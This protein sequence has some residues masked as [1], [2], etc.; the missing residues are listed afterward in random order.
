MKV[1]LTAFSRQKGGVAFS[2]G[3]RDETGTHQ[4]IDHVR[5][6]HTTSSFFD[7]GFVLV[8]SESLALPP[9]VSFFAALL[10]SNRPLLLPLPLLL[11]F[12]LLLLSSMSRAS[13]EPGDEEDRVEPVV[14]GDPVVVAAGDEPVDDG[15]VAVQIVVAAVAVPVDEDDEGDW[16][17]CWCCLGAGEVEGW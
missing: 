9:P 5:V 17:W 2:H 3:K 4:S 12:P 6:V 11:L 13:L 14:D 8:P 10:F 15:V 1:K 16:C 7:F